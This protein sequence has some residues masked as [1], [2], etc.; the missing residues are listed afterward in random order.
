MEETSVNEIAH[1]EE[2]FF[3]GL[4]E[5]RKGSIRENLSVPLVFSHF[6]SSQ[7]FSVNKSRFYNQSEFGACF[8]AMQSYPSGTVLFIRLNVEQPDADVGEKALT[9]LPY[10]NTTLAEVRWCEP[11]ETQDRGNLYKIGI[12]YL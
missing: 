2:H 11:V 4:N 7:L 9:A 8:Y 5:R 10:R 12:K 1:G 6:N 3:S